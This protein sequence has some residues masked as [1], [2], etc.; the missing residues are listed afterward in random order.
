MIFQINVLAVRKCQNDGNIDIIFSGVAK[1]TMDIGLCVK[2]KI[3]ALC[4]KSN[5]K[6]T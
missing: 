1:G 4:A 2:S 6:L 3:A 5:N